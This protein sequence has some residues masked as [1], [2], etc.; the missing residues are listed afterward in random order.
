MKD[1]AHHL[2]HIQKKIIRKARQEQIERKENRKRSH[3]LD[4][5]NVE[6]AEEEVEAVVDLDN[7]RK[8]LSE[9]VRPAAQ[10]DR[11]H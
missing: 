7:R 5:S 3:L 1:T 10:R 8:G 11:V 2:K 9:C 4:G 6:G